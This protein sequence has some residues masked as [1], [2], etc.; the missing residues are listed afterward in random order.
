MNLQYESLVFTAFKN[1]QTA[2]ASPELNEKVF[3]LRKSEICDFEI[4]FGEK[5][6]AFKS[7]QSHIFVDRNR[8]KS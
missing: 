2:V 6:I 7:M 4:N 1:Y 5:N 3:L 8:N